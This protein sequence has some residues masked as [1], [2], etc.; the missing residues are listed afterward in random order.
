MRVFRSEM[1]PNN[2]SLQ[3]NHPDGSMGQKTRPRA[4]ARAYA[5]MDSGD[6]R[7]GDAQIIWRIVKIALRFRIGV[8]IALLATLA[9]AAFQLA[10]P[11]L[12]G[13]AVDGAQSLL[14]DGA[15]TPDA[16]RSALYRAALL[17]LGV[18]IMRGVFTLAHNYCGEAIGHRL[19]H[20]LRL[21]FYEKLQ[22]LGFSFHDRIHTGELITRGML[23]LEGVR[24]LINHGL[25][26]AVQMIVLVGAGA[27]LLLSTDLVLGLLSLS[28]VPY[29][30]WRSTTTR[31]RLRYLWN[32]YQDRLAVLGRIMDENLTGIRVVRAFG[33][34]LFELEKF[35]RSAA[36]ALQL[37]S[38]RIN[39]RVASTTE[40]TFAYFIAM[41]LVLWVGGG[42]GDFGHDFGGNTDRV[43][44]IH[45]HPATSGPLARTGGELSRT[46]IVLRRATVRGD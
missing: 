31:L 24:M 16:V 33:A 15:A 38:R 4:Y 23:D 42:T 7:P 22:R 44:D 32:L 10:I 17:L 37:S 28:F 46:G 13:D 25:L 5:G 3:S 29:I 1:N 12:V 6:S 21:T 2:N 11:G 27:F 9:A 39:V 45:H 34:E 20:N 19:A 30:A 8:A 40:M 36:E 18:S 35:D 14:E 41:A 26:R 43:P